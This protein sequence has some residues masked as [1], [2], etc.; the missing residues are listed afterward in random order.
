MITWI[1]DLWK[2]HHKDKF[3]F[4]FL[5][6]FKWFHSTLEKKI[7]QYGNKITISDIKAIIALNTLK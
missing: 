2:D 3:P 6:M 7:E 1:C 4:N 5:E